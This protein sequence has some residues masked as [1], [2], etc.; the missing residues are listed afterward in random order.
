[1]L[2]AVNV[3]VRVPR[4][5]VPEIRPVPLWLSTKVSPLG[6]VP[7]MVM[8]AVGLATVDTV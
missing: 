3:T 7:V 2:V 8:V 6:N 1:M 5:G 4:A